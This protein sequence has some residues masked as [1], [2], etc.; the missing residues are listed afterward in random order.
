MS[1]CNYTDYISYTQN[2]SI[3]GMEWS[4]TGDS[5]TRRTHTAANGQKRKKGEAF[6]VGSSKLLFP[7][8]SSLGAEAKETIN[9]RC[10]LLAIFEGEELESNTPYDE[11]DAGSQAWLLRQ[12]NLFQTD[13]L[14]NDK[15]RILFE[16]LLF[17]TSNLNKPWKQI[18][19]DIDDKMKANFKYLVDQNIFRDLP[20]H[21]IIGI[22][23]ELSEILDFG[24]DNNKENV[25]VLS[26]DKNNNKK[27]FKNIEADVQSD[28]N[29]DGKGNEHLILN[30]TEKHS[31]TIDEQ[32]DNSLILIHNH[33]DAIP[34]S[35]EDLVMLMKH[36]SIKYLFA[37][38]HNGDIYLI[39]ND[40]R[41]KYNFTELQWQ[42]QINIMH[43]AKDMKVDKAI[44][45]DRIST[46]KD[47]EDVHESYMMNSYKQYDIFYY[48][49]RR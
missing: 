44:A 17:S 24:L 40:N 26:I 19:K 3:I 41:K 45:D 18:K 32:P 33:P 9:C 35:P 27:L 46:H 25:C 1:A 31:K 21:I 7:C 5:R 16:G 15:K 34:L 8:D 49:S 4:A 43:R 20:T 13:Y 48:T 38:G 22:S 6:R 42:V 14:G 30:F 47:I 11:K 39:A 37:V 28:I 12:D 2:K 10:T 29:S 36:K 23:K